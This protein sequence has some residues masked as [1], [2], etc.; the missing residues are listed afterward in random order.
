MNITRICGVVDQSLIVNEP[1][2]NSSERTNET[3]ANSS[4][5]ETLEE[6]K[7]AEKE[8]QVTPKKGDKTPEKKV[9]TTQKEERRPWGRTTQEERLKTSNNKK[10]PRIISDKMLKNEAAEDLMK[11]LDFHRKLR[12]QL[13]RK[14]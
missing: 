2:T 4:G 8:E 14:M 6:S 3:E 11:K 13:A 5:I 1:E 9:R 12:S 10:R 7:P